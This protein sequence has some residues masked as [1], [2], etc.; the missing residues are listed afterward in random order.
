M[1]EAVRLVEVERRRQAGVGQQRDAPRAALA[2][3]R[4]ARV[5]LLLVME[6]DQ[7]VR[8]E[9]RAVQCVERR[10]VLG[11]EGLDANRRDRS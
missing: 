1:L 7:P 2:G 9:P 8:D 5:E 4:E 10:R 3:E 6:L 11:P